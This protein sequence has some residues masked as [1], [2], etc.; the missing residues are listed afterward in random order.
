MKISQIIK[1]KRKSL[2]LT[3]E[4]LAQNIYVSNKTISNW[5]NEKTTPDLESL[6]RLS[7][8]FN[9]SL[10]ELIKGDKKMIKDID[11]KIKKGEYLKIIAFLAV[12]LIVFPLIYKLFPNG[13]TASFLFFGYLII[14]L[15]LAGL[16]ILW[17]L[18]SLLKQMKD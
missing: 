9:I 10:D 5:E 8:F 6:V 4:E 16:I 7:D 13:T 17:G 14:I 12:L 15:I 3:Q 2:N 11:Q 1:D 18:S